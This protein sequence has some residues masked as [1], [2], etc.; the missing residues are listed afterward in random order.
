MK[1]FCFWQGL[2]YWI[3]VMDKLKKKG[4]KNQT[5]G[6]K[7]FHIFPPLPVP[8][9]R[10]GGNC[11][12]LEKWRA[13]FLVRY[14]TPTRKV[15]L[16]PVSASSGPQ[17]NKN[18]FPL[19]VPSWELPCGGQAAHPPTSPSSCS[20]TGHL[21]SLSKWPWLWT[22]PPALHCPYPSRLRGHTFP[23]TSVQSLGYPDS[24]EREEKKRNSESDS[25]KETNWIWVLFT[26]KLLIWVFE[27]S[28]GLSGT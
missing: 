19:E 23:L 5:Q 4:K 12:L 1:N 17:H 28:E 22:L 2:R 27:L 10:W 18:W 20:A 11:R 13:L 26:W 9:F 24:T 7:P 14:L 8:L 25:S 6:H 3:W 16:K 15:K 21:V